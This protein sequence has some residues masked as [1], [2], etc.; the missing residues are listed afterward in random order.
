MPADGAEVLA[1][2]GLLI[3]KQQLYLFIKTIN[4]TNVSLERVREA[5]IYPQRGMIS[6]ENP[7]QHPM[8]DNLLSA[9][10]IDCWLG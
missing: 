6:I 9:D 2:L 8:P 1:I 10:V 7:A 4:I 5:G 3:H